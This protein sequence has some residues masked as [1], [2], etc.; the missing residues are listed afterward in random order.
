MLSRIADSLFWMNRYMERADG[1]LRLTR[2]NY[3][4]GMDT[5]VNGAM[6]WKPVLEI[7]EVSPE[8]EITLI[9]NNTEE[10]LKRILVDVGNDNSLKSLVKRAREN[11]RGAQDHLAKEVWEEINQLFHLVN[12]PSILHKLSTFQSLE[13]LEE[14]TGRTV[15][16]AG[17]ID[18]TMPRGMGWYFMS[19]GRYVERC[20]QTI[21]L[22]EKQLEVLNFSENDTT[23]ILQW[24]HLLLSLSGY[25]LYMKTYRSSNHNYNVL[26]Q[27][28]I[29][30]NFSRSVVYSL[31]R[32]DH[33]LQRVMVNKKASDSALSRSFGRLYSKVKYMELHSLDRPEIQTFLKETK[34][35]LLDFTKQLEQQLFSYS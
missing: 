18:I 2:T 24:Q 10:A 19:L 8:H 11:A 3:I 29:S 25:E 20:L 5:A 23:D 33:Y 32:I 9:Q 26:H 31:K 13:V 1:L 21:L 7:F 22:T 30:E 15:T 4:L 35:E 14:F 16:Y 34:A 28:L 17:I 27:V 12:N 6:T